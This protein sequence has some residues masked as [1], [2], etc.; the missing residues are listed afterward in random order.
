MIDHFVLSSSAS[1]PCSLLW[2]HPSSLACPTLI[3]M[4]PG[5]RSDNVPGVDCNCHPPS[6]QF[7]ALATRTL[8]L[9]LPFSAC[10]PTPVG[11]SVLQ[12]R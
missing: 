6:V 7:D 1:M 5:I 10:A 4:T 2:M 11:S 8:A 9:L 3:K 12:S